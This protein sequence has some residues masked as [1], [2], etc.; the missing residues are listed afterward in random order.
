M[1]EAGADII[2]GHH[3]H[4]LQPTEMVN[5]AAV[6]WGLGNFVWPRHSTAGSTT[7][8][9]RA[10]VHPDGSIEACL[11]PAFIENSGQPVVT[12]E[13]TCGPGR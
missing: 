2:F 11:I 12:G 5:E 1:I 3:A 10:I 6:L 4:R 7:A 9:G 8:I 13:P